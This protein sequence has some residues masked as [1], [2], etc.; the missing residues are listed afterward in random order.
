M[1]IATSS[2]RIVSVFA[3]VSLL[4]CGD[5][6]GGGAGEGGFSG[7]GG[8]SGSGG[9]GAS[10]ADTGGS[11]A[12]S[13]GSG[14]GN[15][16]SDAGSGGSNA[17]SGGAGGVAGGSG[18]G[19]SLTPDELMLEAGNPDG[20]CAIPD[21]AQPE[22][23]S[24]PDHVIGTG[25]PASC[26][27]DAFVDAIAEGGVITF[28]CGE[29]PVTITLT[30]T[31]KVFNDK[32]DVVIDGGGKVTLSGGGQVQILYMNTCD[33]AQVWTTDHC[34]DQ[35]HPTLTVQNI[36][37]DSANNMDEGD[38]GGGAIYAYGGRFKAINSVFTRNRCYHEG[39]EVG[40]AGIRLF[41]QF[42][43]LPAYVVN[44]TFGGS[45][46]LG[47]SCSNGAAL[48]SIGVSWTVLNSLFTHNEAT[49]NGANPAREGSPGGGNGGAIYNDGGEM[50]LRVCGSK[51]ED[52]HAIEG[53]GAIFFVSNDH[54][55]DLIISNS[56]LSGNPS[57]TFETEG[58]PGIFVIAESDPMVTDS[59]IE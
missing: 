36:A 25:T 1:Q 52:N 48:S 6:S 20:D 12:P 42:N 57:D 2:L 28:N 33:Q 43:G 13:G 40:G 49:G 47:N 41:Q 37:F 23:V 9:G 15:G 22:D 53:G 59:T 46:E 35:D 30:E 26:T 45:E 50:T 17:G 31:A 11:G 55:G 44:C 54:T 14:A 51:F 29:D 24:R 34:N 8:E 4:A 58:Y 27:A 39:A 19:T 21:E 38:E 7:E 32:P 5:D 56:V 16:G 10:G 18:G 3:L